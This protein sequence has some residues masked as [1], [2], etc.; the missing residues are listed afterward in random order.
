MGTDHTKEYKV[1]DINSTDSL[2]FYD[3]FDK[4][5]NFLGTAVQTFDKEGFGGEI[6][7]LVSFNEDGNIIKTFALE[8]LETPGL[9]DKISNSK[10]DFYKQFENKNPKEFTLM[11]KKDRGDVDAITA[12]TI[13]SRAYCRA[14][15][16]A[17]DAY[18]AEKG[19]EK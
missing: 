5:E 6:I 14:V 4:S 16:K 17:V 13:S 10:S 7:L 15:Q 1:K 8:Q 9:G 11:V 12:A 19:G 3:A 18:N 2:I